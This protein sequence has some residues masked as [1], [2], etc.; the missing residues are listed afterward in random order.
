MRG[1]VPWK[2]CAHIGGSLCSLEYNRDRWKLDPLLRSEHETREWSMETPVEPWP[3]RVQQ[4]KSA[5]EVLLIAFFDCCGLVYQHYCPPKTRIN[6]EYYLKTSEK[7]REHIWRKRSDLR[8]QFILHQDNAR[9]HTAS[10]VQQW[11]G[12]HNIQMFNHSPYGPDLRP[13]I[14]GSSQP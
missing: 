3:K 4:Q 1:G 7:L 8:N 13:V 11:L 2:S 5:G 12:E 10:I 9:P 6:A 14:F